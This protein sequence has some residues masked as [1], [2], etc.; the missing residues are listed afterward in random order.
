[1]M[2]ARGTAAPFAVWMALFTVI[3]LGVVVYYAFTNADGAFTLEN[4]F[5]IKEYAGS[6]LRSFWI[7]ILSTFICLLLAYP[8]AFSISRSKGRVQQTMVMLIMMPMWMNFL[9]RTYAWQSLLENNGFI[10]QFLGWFGIPPI[11]MINTTGAVIL[12]M[13]YNFLPFMILPLYSVMV[14]I[15][16]SVIEA[17]Q[18]LGSNTLQVFSRVILPL[19]V[20]GIISGIT[21][22]FIPI[23]STFAITQILGGSLINMIGDNIEMKFFGAAPDYNVG[24]A[25]ALL[26]MILLLISMGIMN[27]FDKNGEEV[28]A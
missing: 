4:I 18:D 12:G 8:L 10:N 2:K 28:G 7:G 6:L 26:L 3:P 19:S 14:K 15:D 27:H 20:P 17:A 5:S 23:I 11:Q 22:V 24:S 9:L 21:M 25:L 16:K 1:M 13:V